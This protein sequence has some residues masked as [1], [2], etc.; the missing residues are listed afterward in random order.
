M[1]NNEFIENFNFEKIKRIESNILIK[2]IEIDEK[3]Y[4]ILFGTNLINLDLKFEDLTFD[5]FQFKINEIGMM[6][7]EVYVHSVSTNKISNLD[8]FMFYTRFIENKDLKINNL[9]SFK[10]EGLLNKSD[11]KENFD[12]YFNEIFLEN[13]NAL[14]KIDYDNYFEG[15]I[16]FNEPS[17]I[18]MGCRI[19]NKFWCFTYNPY[20]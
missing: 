2:N 15:Y 17:V 5:E 18:V 4:R 16:Y 6:F 11:F 13:K 7:S 12:L 20:I 14:I 19:E 1:T 8:E 9:Y 10:K 3:Y